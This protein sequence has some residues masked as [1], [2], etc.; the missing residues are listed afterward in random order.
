MKFFKNTVFIIAAASMIVADII[1][2]MLP[3]LDGYVKRD[4]IVIL[5]GIISPRADEIRDAVKKYGYKI[6][7]EES[8]NDW[9]AMLITGEV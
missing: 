7:C 4:G 1:L 6:L 2:R 5:S 3:D 8:E 9:L